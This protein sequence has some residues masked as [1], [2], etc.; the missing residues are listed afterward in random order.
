MRDVASPRKHMSASDIRSGRAQEVV[1]S[2]R[3]SQMLG[4]LSTAMWSALGRPIM[5]C[6]NGLLVLVSFVVCDDGF[7]TI[8]V[9]MQIELGNRVIVTR[10]RLDGPGDRNLLPLPHAEERIKR[11][12][13]P[14][15]ADIKM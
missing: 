12:G 5:D 13:I 2:A 1:R 11:K 7:S 3:R 15:L 14:S 8:P 6:R 9:G 4:L 10:T